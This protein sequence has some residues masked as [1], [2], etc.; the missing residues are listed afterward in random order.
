[1]LL[2]YKRHEPQTK[3]LKTFLFLIFFRRSNGFGSVSEVPET[4]FLSEKGFKLQDTQGESG[5]AI[6][7]SVKKATLGWLTE[8]VVELRQSRH[9]MSTTRT[10]LTGLGIVLLITGLVAVISIFK[11]TVI[12][13]PGF[14]PTELKAGDS[15][16]V[17]VNKIT[18]Q[19][20]QV[21]FAW[22]D[23]PGVC[24]PSKQQR[25][26]I[27]ENLGE[28]LMGDRMEQSLYSVRA[29]ATSKGLYNPNFDV[30]NLN[31]SF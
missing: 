22:H 8:F 23:V 5:D 28:V 14:H 16:R 1:M 29:L 24:K 30:S 19:Y 15:L 26:K 18:S 17:T 13:V 9:S 27:H 31:L 11:D 20:T 25:V 3:V 6:E 4:L 10:I 12:I 21:P 7:G 2:P